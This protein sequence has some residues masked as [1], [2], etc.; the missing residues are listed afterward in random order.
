MS[1]RRIEVLV[2]YGT[3][4]EAIKMA[5][6]IEALDRRRDQVELIVC[7]TGQHRE[8]LDQAQEVFGIRPDIDLDLMR[9]EQSLNQLASRGFEALDKVLDARK[10]DWLLVQ[11]DTTT[12]WVGAFAAFHRGIK[13]GHVE[14]GL[15]TGN[16]REPFPEEANRRAIDLVSEALFAPTKHAA[17][18]LLGEGIDPARVCLTGNTVVDALRGIAERL[19][20][21]SAAGEVLVSVH[22]RESFGDPLREIF[23]ALRQLAATFTDTRF[24]YPV[25]RNPNVWEPAHEL[26]GG[27]ANI[28]LKEPLDYLDLLGCLKSAR[29]VLTD[30]GGIQ[31]EAP[32]FGIP[33]LVLRDTTERPEGIDA[34]VA[35]LVGTDRR[36]IVMEVS[37]LLRD[38]DAHARM[39]RVVDLYGDGCAAERIAAVL[40]G[41]DFE[42][43]EPPGG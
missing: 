5:P 24:I 32:T 39:A 21:D 17:E 43:F 15:R 34:G 38:D 35:R 31:E 26:L 28:E 13:V 1:H 29:L 2:L 20:R 9:P 12:A 14:A 18:T 11:G 36:R 40:T 10:P 23:A 4:P 7:T 37:R 41:E 19:P 27:I 42:P 25:H 16:L 8:L 30:S 3:R 33:I 6:V 22:R